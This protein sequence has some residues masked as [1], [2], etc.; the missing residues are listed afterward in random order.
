MH[1]ELGIGS[2]GNM[3]DRP[4]EMEKNLEYVNFGNNY[5]VWKLSLGKSFT[6]VLLSNNGVKCIGDNT[7][8]SWGMVIQLQEVVT[9]KF[10]GSFAIC[11]FHTPGSSVLISMSAGDQFCCVLFNDSTAKCW[12]K[13]VTV[14]PE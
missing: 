8:V 2:I 13:T 3:G 10:W 4:G 12:G 7:L 1:G 5:S 9:R 14:S 11:R 6:C